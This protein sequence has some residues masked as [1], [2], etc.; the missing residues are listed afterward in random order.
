[1]KAKK[2]INYGF[3]FSICCCLIVLAIFAVMS[4]QMGLAKKQ[5]VQDSER[6]QTLN[7]DAL[8]IEAGD[9]QK[10]LAPD[11]TP[12][13]LESLADVIADKQWQKVA[14]QM[15]AFFADK[16]TFDRH[17]KALK[18]VIRE[19][20]KSQFMVDSYMIED[21][22]PGVFKWN[23]LKKATVTCGL[24]VLLDFSNRDTAAGFSSQEYSYLSGTVYWQKMGDSW[25]I[26][27][28]GPI[29]PDELINAGKYNYKYGSYY[30]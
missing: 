10:V 30:D 21:E 12:Q 22:D 14:D 23:M 19:S 27:K 1:M 13:E 8:T 4:Y 29:F 16:L 24:N 26:Y 18:D 20:V 3:I 2:K 15:Q 17:E 11:V 25:Q 9:S 7:L 5:L 28:A 6:Y